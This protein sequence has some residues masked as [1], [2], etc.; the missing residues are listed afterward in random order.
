M[1]NDISPNSLNPSSDTFADI[2]NHFSLQYRKF[3]FLILCAIS[4]FTF[5]SFVVERIVVF[6]DSMSG[7]YENGSILLSQKFN[8]GNISRYDVVV[9]S[10]GKYNAIKRIIGMPGET[11]KI[12]NS[13]VY[14]NNV[15]IRGVFGYAPGFE[16]TWHL[17]N[18][19]YFV[20]GDNRAISID[21]RSYGS[22]LFDKILGKVI[23]QIFPLNN[24]G[25]S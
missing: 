13:I 22:V 2:S 21:S 5:R 4:I 17:A 7:S 1:K 25:Y 12:Q 15:E 20:L 10:T 6:G 16:G 9:V 14:I 19:E 18:N 24:I 8:L 3:G 11:V 23:F